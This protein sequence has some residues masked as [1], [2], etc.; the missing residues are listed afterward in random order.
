MIPTTHEPTYARS[1]DV[2]RTVGAA[3]NVRGRFIQLY[4][5]LRHM[6]N[7]LPGLGS[8]TAVPA[9]AIETHLD[10][11]F[12]KTSRPEPFVV[13]TDL[14]GQSTS[15]TAPYSTRTGMKAPGHAYATNTWRN[16]LGIQKGVGCPASATV[17]NALLADPNIRLAC[18]HMAVDSE[19]RQTCG[20]EGT[21]YRGDQHSIWLKRAPDGYQVVD[22]DNPATYES[23]LRPRVAVP[24]F[25]LMGALYSFAS[26]GT[27]PDREQVSLPEFAADFGLGVDQLESMLDIDPD[28][29]G[30][31]A[32][33]T[34]ASGLP[35]PAPQP[36]PQVGPGV[37]VAV[38]PVGGPVPAAAAPIQVN[39]GVGAEIAVAHELQARGWTVTYFGSQRNIGYDLE[40][41]RDGVVL[42]VE[43]KSSV[44]VCVPELS[45]AEWQAAQAHGENYILAIVDF[46]GSQTPRF[47]YVRDPAAHVPPIEIY[48]RN[49]RLPRADVQPLATDAEFL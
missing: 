10:Q 20:I 23:Y 11:L 37:G 39:T 34:V 18:P 17:I 49:Y 8:Q 22:L 48:V 38:P 29:E 42:R 6:R 43:V 44:G 12:T 24:A 26:S 36:I 15:P 27:F 13:L 47:L 1:L 33:L 5:G 35:L 14:F 46:A 16:N 41:S 25:A 31:A 9:G 40:A 28:S 32:V 30:N 45:E 3:P 4:L 21:V 19:G 7:Q 2:L